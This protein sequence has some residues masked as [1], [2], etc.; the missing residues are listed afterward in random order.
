MVLGDFYSQ[1]GINVQ[2]VIE[3]GIKTIDELY[4]GAKISIKV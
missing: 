2:K 1:V 4:G 3:K